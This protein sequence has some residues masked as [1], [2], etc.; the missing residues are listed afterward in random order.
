MVDKEGEIT[1]QEQIQGLAFASVSVSKADQEHI[2]K[3]TIYL[4]H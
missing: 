3:I 4:L 1:H 2:N